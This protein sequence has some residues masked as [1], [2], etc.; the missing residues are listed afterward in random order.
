MIKRKK[1][2][3]FFIIFIICIILTGCEN[4]SITENTRSKIIQCLEDNGYIS[5]NDTF[6]MNKSFSSDYLFYHILYYEYVYED[7]VGD[8]YSIQI[9]PKKK[10]TSEYNIRINY[11]VKL[12][13]YEN[14]NE[15]YILIGHSSDYEDCKIKEIIKKNIF[16]KEIRYEISKTS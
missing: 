16:K 2:Y 3:L 1:I 11:D 13:E 5:I 6:I 4:G 8:L 15:T 9:Y 7:N 10:K 12:E 14:Q